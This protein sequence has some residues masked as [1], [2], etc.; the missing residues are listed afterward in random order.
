MVRVSIQLASHL[1][2]PYPLSFRRLLRRSIPISYASLAYL[3]PSQTLIPTHSGYAN[4]SGIF[5]SKHQIAI[6]RYYFIAPTAMA[7]D[8]D[9]SDRSNSSVVRIVLLFILLSLAVTLISVALRYLYVRRRSTRYN[10]VQGGSRPVD[11]EAAPPEMHSR[12]V[13]PDAFPEIEGHYAPSAPAP[14]AVAPRAGEWDDSEARSTEYQGYFAPSDINY[15][16]SSTGGQ[17][18]KPFLA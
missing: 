1:I 9:S 8:N 15:S 12:Q 17:S 2:S 10:L 7:D 11:P 14:A 18:A 13:A 5:H 16:S 3:T 6:S 4:S